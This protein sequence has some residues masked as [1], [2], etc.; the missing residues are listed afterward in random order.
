MYV[1]RNLVNIVRI[2][3]EFGVELVV[4]NVWYHSIWKF[5]FLNN[6]NSQLDATTTILLII[7][8]SSTCFGR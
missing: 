3:M 8:I 1:R 7:S 4:K 2:L 5:N 6:I